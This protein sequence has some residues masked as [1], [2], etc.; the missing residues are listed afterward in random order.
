MCRLKGEGK[1]KRKENIREREKRCLFKDL[2]L[3]VDD[4]ES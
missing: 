2:D 3:R 4:R 1:E